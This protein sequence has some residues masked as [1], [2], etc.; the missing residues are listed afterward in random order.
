[1]ICPS[2]L[3]R[4]NLFPVLGTIVSIFSISVAL[5]TEGVPKSAFAADAVSTASPTE[6]KPGWY[7]PTDPF[8]CSDILT[9]SVDGNTLYSETGYEAVSGRY[10]CNPDGL[11]IYTRVGNS[12]VYEDRCNR[13]TILSPDSLQWGYTDAPL[14]SSHGAPER[15]AF[16]AGSYSPNH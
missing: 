6:F 13:V 4:K 5:A 2:S 14:C 10:D 7:R 11:H 9:M 3:S 1:M 12:A 15:L 16:Y 8:I